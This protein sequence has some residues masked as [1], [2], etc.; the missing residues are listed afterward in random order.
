MSRRPRVGSP[1][2]PTRSGLP[3][4][5]LALFLTLALVGCG[6][7]PKKG[8]PLRVG[9]A[10]SVEQRLLAQMTMIMLR[11]HGYQVIDK[12]ELGQPWMVRAALEADSIDICWEYTENTYVLYLDHD[13]PIADP[14]W[15]YNEVVREDAKHRIAWVAMAPAQHTLSVVVRPEY[16]QQHNL[17]TLADLA[18]HVEGFKPQTRLCVPEAFYAPAHGIGGIERVYGFRFDEREV[19]FESLDDALAVLA[20]G[21]CDCALSTDAA[22]VVNRGLVAL[23][24]SAGFFRAS[25]LAVAVRANRLLDDAEL[26]EPLTRLAAALDTETLA[27]LRAEVVDRGQNPAKVARRFLSKRELIAV[28][29]LPPTRTP[30]IEPTPKGGGPT[31]TVTPTS[32]ATPDV[33]Q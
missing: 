26:E 14:V 11:S 2:R 3:L 19:R 25:N 13:H 24:D 9:A 1:I 10:D 18:R 12:T 22:E 4:L 8:E 32:T 23:D 6:P 7:A 5:L 20:K 21:G 27:A 33:R 31:A 30:T 15:L 29:W 28:R 16:A 17:R